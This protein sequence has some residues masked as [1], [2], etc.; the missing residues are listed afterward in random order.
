MQRGKVGVTMSRPK[1][2]N[3][4][5][6]SLRIPPEWASALEAIAAAKSSAGLKL[7]RSDALRVC[8]AAGIEAVAAEHGI[9]VKLK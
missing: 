5:Q 9:T 1:T 6:L 7:S 3:A 4:L 2:D 8:L